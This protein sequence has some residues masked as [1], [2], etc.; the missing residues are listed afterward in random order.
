MMQ[1]VLSSCLIFGLLLTGCAVGPNYKRPTM[2]NPPKYVSKNILAPTTKANTSQGNAQRFLITQDLPAQ[3]WELFHSKPLNDLILTSLQHN[4]DVMAAKASVRV[5]LENL[6]AQRGALYPALGASFTPSVEQLSKV[7][8]SL[9]ASNEY[10][11]ALYTA[12]V[13]VSY[14][15]DVFGGIRR[16]IESLVALT[17][18][19]RFQLEATYIT[20]TTNVANAAIQEASLREQIAITQNLIASQTKV[21][22]I[23]KQ[24]MQM[25]VAAIT[26]VTTQEAALAAFETTLPPLE[27]QLAL[28]R[29]QLN[30]LTGRFPDDANTPKFFLHSLTLPTELPLSLPS[31]LIEHRPDI[32]A[33]EEQM[34]AANA[35]IGV[36]VAN[37]LPNINIGF[38][39]AG[40]LATNLTE[41]FAPHA[42]FWSL[43]G[44]ITEPIFDAGT[45][46]HRQRAAMAAY[47]QTAAQYRATVINAFQNVA[48]S[49]KAIQWDA[50]ALQAAK[51]SE[52]AARTNLDITRRQL[53]LGDANS[54]S[55]LI[56]EQLYHQAELSLVQAKANRL[57]DTVALFQAV[58]G[59]WWN[60][61]PNCKPHE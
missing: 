30:A 29:D 37:R 8:T 1:N 27:K 7:L 53:Q 25:G 34:R 56:S 20:L 9:L 24:R 13:F 59:G 41:L 52:T 17:E 6:Y 43:A 5:A 14:T 54:L 18:L 12:Q 33:A 35:L 36:A 19:Q 51:K 38:T 11:Y 4:Q 40:L 21:V 39:N 15:P 42:K 22:S 50:K 16:Q 60:R 55:V 28:Q 10:N 45:L 46:L 31:T 44:I 32:R 47:D 58:G 26:D 3:W 61:S 57:S 23:F 48:D 2:A 49:I